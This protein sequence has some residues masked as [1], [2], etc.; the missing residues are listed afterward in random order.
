MKIKQ[1]IIRIDSIEEFLKDVG[2]C[3]VA[4]DAKYVIDVDVVK[5]AVEKALK[6]WK[7]GRN[8][9]K[10]L[11]LEILLYF[12]A[13]RQIRDAVKVGIKEGINEVVLVLLDNCENKLE[14][15]SFEE[16]DVVR[17]D[18][19]RIENIKRL[20]KICDEEFEIVGVEKLPMLIR[21]RIA[22]FDIFK[23]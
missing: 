8:V 13:T 3:V 2:E 5:F 21:E 4:I 12:S 14:K 22:L 23:T 15:Y 18:E 16:V 19:D 9:A 17:I 20:Y 7:E 6:S 1:G 10:N 11:P